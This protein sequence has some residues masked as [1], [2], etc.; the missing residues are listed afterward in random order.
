MFI[1]SQQPVIT[2]LGTGLSLTNICWIFSLWP[3]YSTQFSQLFSEIVIYIQMN[4]CNSI[5]E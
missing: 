2:G 1:E 3:N 5:G 4:K